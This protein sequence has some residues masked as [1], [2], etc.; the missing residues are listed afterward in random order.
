MPVGKPTLY[1][2]PVPHSPTSHIGLLN[3]ADAASE[4]Q[5]AKNLRLFNFK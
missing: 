3:T 2:H 1:G 5:G 4:T